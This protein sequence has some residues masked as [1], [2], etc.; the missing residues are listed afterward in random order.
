V[1]KFLANPLLAHWKKTLPTH[2]IKKID[3][4]VENF[5]SFNSLDWMG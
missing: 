1:E 2:Q 4:L 3:G 5:G